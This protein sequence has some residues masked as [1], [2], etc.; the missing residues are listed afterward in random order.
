M[1]IRWSCYYPPPP[2]PCPLLASHLA[3]NEAVIRM[4]IDI[5]SPD[6]VEAYIEKVKKKEKVLSG[7]GHRIYRTSDPRSFII[8]KTAE[9][10]SMGGRAACT[11][12]FCR[13]VCCQD[14]SRPIADSGN[15]GHPKL[16]LAIPS[17]RSLLLRRR[18]HSWRLP[19]ASTTSLFKMTTS[20][21]AGCTRTLISTPDSCISNWAG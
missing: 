10:V 14:F 19:C 11:I 1:H 12:Y 16:Y 8:R 18:T 15:I 6:N 3:A 5:G 7:F 9:E 4:L 20:S 17:A 2:S 13:A 21:P